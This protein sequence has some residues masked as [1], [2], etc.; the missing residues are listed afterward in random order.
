MNDTRLNVRTCYYFRVQR[1]IFHPLCLLLSLRKTLDSLMKQYLLEVC[2]CFERFKHILFHFLSHKER[3][4][5]YSITY[6]QLY[7]K[8]FSYPR[9]TCGSLF[10]QLLNFFAGGWGIRYGGLGRVRATPLTLDCFF[11]TT[12]LLTSNY[13]A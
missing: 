12:F 3:N 9:S 1:L 7:R 6:I 13:Q 4:D 5:D 10:S 11:L 8:M 2:M